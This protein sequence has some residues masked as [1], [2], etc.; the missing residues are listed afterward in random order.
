MGVAAPRFQAGAG[1]SDKSA[2]SIIVGVA[3]YL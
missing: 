1:Y 3:P 2:M